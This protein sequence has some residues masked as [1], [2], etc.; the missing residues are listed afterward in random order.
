MSVIY[1]FNVKNGDCSLIQH[2][3]GRNTVIDVCNGN[4]EPVEEKFDYVG[5][6]NQKNHPVNP[7]NEMENIGIDG[8]FRFILT[9]PDMDHMDGIQNLFNTFDV[10]NFWDTDNN[11]ETDE[12]G[13]G[14]YS[15]DDWN[16]YQ[17]IRKS[18]KSPKT[19]RLLAGE[20]KEYWEEDKISILSPTQGLVDTANE[21]KEYNNISYVLLFQENKK[22]ILFCGD[23]EKEAWNGI[24]SSYEDELTD[25]DILIAPH[26]GRKSGGNDD[27]LDTLNPKLTLF[28]NASSKDLDYS[29]W[30]SRDLPH[31]TNNEGGTFVFSVENSGIDV[32]CTY[33]NFAKQQNKDSFWNRDYKAWYIGTIE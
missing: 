32:Y 19:L 29:A 18:K 3:S 12:S 14:E 10:Q 22:K 33:E 13:W 23:S 2:N 27:Y 6:H 7:V 26:H 17:E 16:F 31:F 28:G 30:N 11:K 1:F 4:A 15:E 20:S 8:I 21:K 5:N 25:I 9:H 24:M